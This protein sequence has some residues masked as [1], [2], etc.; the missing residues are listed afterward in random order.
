MRDLRSHSLKSR[1][2]TNIGILDALRRRYPDHT[3]TQ[4][5]KS[6]GVLKFVKAGQAYAA[7]D[8]HTEFYT[9][10]TYKLATDNGKGTGRL[11]YKMEF[12]RYNYR[13]KYL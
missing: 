5:L 4:T 10:R 11:K 13:Y 6:T 9:S 7:L 1:V 8:T 2:M 12:G 3:V